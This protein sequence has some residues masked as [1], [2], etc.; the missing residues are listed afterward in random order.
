MGED[1]EGESS[2]VLLRR[3]AKPPSPGVDAADTDADG[4]ADKLELT[5]GAA[6]NDLR[7][8]ARLAMALARGESAGAGDVAASG[9]WSV[10][11]IGRGA[12]RA[13]NTGPLAD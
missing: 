4:A 11:T 5:C 9:A 3:S 7:L 8:A 13:R 6:A 10:V 1:D 2:I 12:A